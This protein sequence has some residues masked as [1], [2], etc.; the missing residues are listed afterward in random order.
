MA[1][2]DS[3]CGRSSLG[4]SSLSYSWAFLPQYISYKTRRVRTAEFVCGNIVS[5]IRRKGFDSKSIRY[6]SVDRVSA[7][8]VPM[9]RDVFAVRDLEWNE[10]IEKLMSLGM[11]ES[12]AVKSLERAFGWSGQ[13]YWRNEKVEQVPTKEKIEVVLDFLCNIGIEDAKSHVTIIKKFPEI[14]GL[15]AELMKSNVAKLQSAYFLKGKAL[16][17]SIQRK[18]RVLGSIV[19]CEGSCQGYCTRC[20]A[21]F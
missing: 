19:D 2:L 18:P 20:F 9:S 4:G 1:M 12:E 5:A 21:Q 16:A 10:S 8:A 3:T 17:N 7:S 14:L 13:S 11:D 15:E 6:R